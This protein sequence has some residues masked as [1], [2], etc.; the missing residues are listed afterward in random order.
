MT[1]RD[2]EILATLQEMLANQREALAAQRTA[3]AAQE[4]ALANQEE[5]IA[6]QKL[7]IARQVAHLKLYRMVLIVGV[8]LVGVLVWVFF[9]VAG[10]Y[11]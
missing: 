5:S 1:G 3:L 2:D 11:L 7:A 10:P 8:P 4:K 6:Q 9:R